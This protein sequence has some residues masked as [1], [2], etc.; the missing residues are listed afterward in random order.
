MVT[1]NLRQIGL[2]LHNYNETYKRLPP[3]VLYNK[4]GKPLLSWRVLL[5][6]FLEQN[7]LFQQFKLDEPWDGPHNSKLL[8]K[9][10]NVY[11]P[12]R[13]K[14]EPYTTYYQVFDGPE[15]AFDSDPHHGLRRFPLAEPGVSVFEGG[16]VTKI[17]ASFPRGTARTLILAEAGQAVPW[18]KPTDLH[19]ASDR[20]IPPLGGQF[21][22]PPTL[23]R[24]QRIMGIHVLF[25]D[26]SVFFLRMEIDEVTL[27]N[28]IIRKGDN[29]VN[30]DSLF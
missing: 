24:S 11:T 2:A 20:P 26:A 14:Y 29:E 13:G 30:W 23:F 28:L 15:A 10:P 22:E 18:T 21:N 6:P 5:L 9:M 17:P 12:V 25:A 4:E 8:A 7:E 19:V 3:A 16:R 27:R 1:N